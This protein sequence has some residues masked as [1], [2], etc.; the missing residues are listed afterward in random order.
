MSVPDVL[1]AI[2]AAGASRRLGTAKQLVPVDGE[3]L[4]RRQCRCALSA[5]IGSVIVILGCDAERHA[6]V[7]ADLP[8]DVCV[9][10]EWPEGMA[11]SLRHA[12]GAASER[13]AASLI[14]PCDQ[15]RITP[16][17]LRSLYDTWRLAP[18]AACLSCWDDYVGP[19]AI[20]PSEY[21]EDVRQLRGDVGARAVVS[22]RSLPRPLGVANPRATY[23][24]DWPEDLTIANTREGD[25]H[26]RP[27]DPAHRI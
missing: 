9:N 23:D 10:H 3:P 4:L 18:S 25:R 6:H 14:L 12:V 17:D 8:V 2:L 15:F 19:P 1:I 21:Y 24:L 7:I 26:L 13:R 20:L 22:A 11:A 5:G 16:G 27:I